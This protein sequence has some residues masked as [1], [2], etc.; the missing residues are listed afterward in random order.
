ME[1]RTDYTKVDRGVFEVIVGSREIPP[2]IVGLTRS[3][4]T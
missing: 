2:W 4:K 3:F 1:S